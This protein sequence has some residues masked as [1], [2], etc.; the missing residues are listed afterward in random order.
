MSYVKIV[1][2]AVDEYPYSEAK[3]RQDNPT[4]SFPRSMTDDHLERWGVYR[5]TR[6]AKPSY[7][8]RTQYLAL[9]SQPTLSNG[10]WVLNYT[11]TDKTSD[12]IQAYDDNAAS[13]NR[14]ARDGLL[15]QTDFYALSDVTMSAAMTTYRQELRD[16]TTH[17]NWPNLADDDWPTKP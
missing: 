16:I 11:A 5:V 4:V 14:A 2:N 10:S 12:E 3:L 17:A 15:A 1:N 13:E 9:D 7:N 8:S 6:G